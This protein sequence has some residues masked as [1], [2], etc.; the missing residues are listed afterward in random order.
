MADYTAIYSVGNSIAQYLQNAY[1]PALASSFPCQFKLVSST[2]IALEGQTAL[3]QVVSIFLH[4]VTT[5]ENF[6]N[7]TLLPDAPTKQPAVF[8]DLHYLLTYWGTSAQAEQTILGWAV[9]QLQSSPILDNSILLNASIPASD[10]TW[11]ATE[12]VQLVMADLSLEDIL[13]IWDALGPKYR[14]SVAY[15]ARVV[16]IDRSFAPAGPVVATRFTL[17]QE[18]V[19]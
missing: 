7:A 10:K 9:Q 13:R 2:E 6:R 4:R 16:R 18:P 11:G 3:D 1:P 17:E 5:N 15:L 12:S 8:L 14:L 19:S